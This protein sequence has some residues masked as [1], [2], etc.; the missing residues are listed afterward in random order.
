MAELTRWQDLPRAGLST[1][2]SAAQSVTGDWRTAGKPVVD[3]PR[4]VNCLLCWM[5]C[6]DSAI[7]LDG[8]T[9]S[10]VDYTVCKGCELC[11]EVCP[12]GAIQMGEEEAS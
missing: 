11:V 1:P 5:Y 8:T 6:P 7:V 3:F 9:F 2:G 12:V 10:S 4:C